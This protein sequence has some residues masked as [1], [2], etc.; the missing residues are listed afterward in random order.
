MAQAL[1]GAA[2][3]TRWTKIQR[4]FAFYVVDL[5]AVRGG[6]DLSAVFAFQRV[7]GSPIWLQRH[8]KSA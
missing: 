5:F 6:G 7:H 2:K 1:T 8:K 4:A 3:T